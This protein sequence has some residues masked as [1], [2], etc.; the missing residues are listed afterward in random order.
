MKLEITERM[1]K[2]LRS[3]IETRGGFKERL[4]LFFAR[5]LLKEWN[6]EAGSERWWR[7]GS[8]LVP[9]KGVGHFKVSTR[10]MAVVPDRLTVRSGR[11]IRAARGKQG[12]VGRVAVNEKGFEVV[13]GVQGIPYAARQE[14][15][16]GGARS[17]VRRAAK[18]M[19]D[20][21]AAVLWKKSIREAVNAESG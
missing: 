12:G 10:L 8:V 15:Q 17:Y 20:H 5:N 6:K 16:K 4:Y 18:Y 3:L 21:V 7:K 13:K 14:Y 19:L 1:S 9:F 11:L 2:R